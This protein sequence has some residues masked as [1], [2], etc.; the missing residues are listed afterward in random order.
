MRKEIS[1]FA[2]RLVVAELLSEVVAWIALAGAS[3]VAIM[4]WPNGSTLGGNSI[5]Q[6]V[7]YVAIATKIVSF[8]IIFLNPP[9]FLKRFG[10]QE[11]WGNTGSSKIVSAIL[12]VIVVFGLHAVYWQAQKMQYQNCLENGSSWDQCRYYA[13]DSSKLFFVF[14]S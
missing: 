10:S 5:E 11:L 8:I 12:A 14:I 6:W 4:V 2:I 1:I 7:S 9:T 13:P 3:L